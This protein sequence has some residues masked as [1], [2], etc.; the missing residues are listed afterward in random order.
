MKKILVPTDFSTYAKKG[1]MF[2]IQWATQQKIELVFIHV[3]SVLRPTRISDDHFEKYLEQEVNS[4][5]EKLEKHIIDLYSKMDVDPGKYSVLVISGVSADISLLDYCRNNPGIDAICISTRGAGKLNKILGTN[6]G[7][8]I[9][10]ST[11]PVLAVPQ[12]YR[13][14]EIH[15]LMYATDF[16]NYE[17]EM[18][19]VVVFAKPLKAKIEILHISWPTEIPFDQKTMEEVFKKKFNYDM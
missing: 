14:S 4:C 8:L 18:K 2:A 11:V 15:T 12:N 6:K 17:D 7:N 16:K 9:A 10:Q 5:R 19:K 3:L 1:L 13:A